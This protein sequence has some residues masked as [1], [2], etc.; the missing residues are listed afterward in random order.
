MAKDSD[1]PVDPTSKRQRLAAICGNPGLWK[2]CE[3]CERVV[4]VIHDFC[5]KCHAYRFDRAA[6]RVKAAARKAAR[7]AGDELCL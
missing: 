6:E 4:G 7:R 3:G 1:I 5:P 2:V